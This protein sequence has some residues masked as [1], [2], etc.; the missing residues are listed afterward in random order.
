MRILDNID[1]VKLTKTYEILNALSTKPNKYTFPKVK[2]NPKELN[3]VLTYLE[4]IGFVESESSFFGLNKK[5]K[6]TEYGGL[7][8]KY[9]NEN[10]LDEFFIYLFKND[11]SILKLVEM[12][13][14]K[15]IITYNDILNTF[16]I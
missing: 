16:K 10:K 3:A 15:K 14:N 8:L 2:I 7:F 11:E 12:I 13:F 5:Y 6:L 4:K 9:Y 1:K